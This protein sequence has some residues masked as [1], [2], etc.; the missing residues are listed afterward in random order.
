MAR[1]ERWPG[2]VDIRVSVS[3]STVLVISAGKPN[4]V[5]AKPSPKAYPAKFHH[6]RSFLDEGE[7]GST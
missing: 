5:S 1:Q 6:L 2:A 3:G 7:E 4:P